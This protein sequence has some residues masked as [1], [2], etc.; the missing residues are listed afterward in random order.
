MRDLHEIEERLRQYAVLSAKDVTA[1]NATAQ[2]AAIAA[3]VASNRSVRFLVVLPDEKEAEELYEA[4]RAFTSTP[5]LLLPAWDVLPFE[6]SSLEPSIAA[7]RVESL[8]FLAGIDLP[9]FGIERPN[10]CIASARAVSRL[11]LSTELWHLLSKKISFAD[12]LPPHDLRKYLIESGYSHSAEVGLPGE[13]ASRGGILDFYSPG[14]LY[15]I[16]I[17]WDGDIIE[18]LR[19]F[20]PMTQRTID[21]VDSALILPPR[22]LHLPLEDDLRQE[23]IEQIEKELKPSLRLERFKDAIRSRNLIEG[24]ELFQTFFGGMTSA[25][26]LGKLN[27]ICVDKERIESRLEELFE[28]ASSESKES[29][30]GFKP[31]FLFSEALEADLQYD[32]MKTLPD[33]VLPQIE[34]EHLPASEVDARILRI[35]ISRLIDRDDEIII[36]TSFGSRVKELLSEEHIDKKNVNVIEGNLRSGARLPA[37]RIS[38]IGDEDI[39]GRIK[40]RIRKGISRRGR[41]DWRELNPGDYVVHVNH[42]VGIFRGIERIVSLGEERDVILIEYAEND[43]LYLPPHETGMLEKYSVLEGQTPRI[44]KLGAATWS[45]MRKRAERETAEIA[46]EL[47]DLYALRRATPGVI[48]PVSPSEESFEKTFGYDET[49][50]QMRAIEEVLGELSNKNCREPMDRLLCG[51][52]GY[53]KTEVA[54]R[55]TFRVV[56]NGKQVA[57]L[58]PTT[59]LALQH[60][61]TFKERLTPFGISVG[62]LS[63]FQSVHEIT[64]NLEKLGDGSLNVIIGTHKLFGQSVRFKDL[65]LVIVDEE[66]RFGVRHKE[67]L[68]ELRKRVDI[69]TLTATPIP[70]TLH[71]ALS[72]AKQL[73]MIETPPPGRAPIQTV[74]E[75]FNE[76]HVRRAIRRELDRG[77]QVFYVHNRIETIERVEQF[78]KR[79]FPKIPMAVAHGAMNERELSKVML[80]FISGKVSI[81]ISTSIIENG[82]DIPK[83]NTMIIDQAERFGLAQLYQLR[84]R[85]GRSNTKA[86]SYFFH[87]RDMTADARARLAAIAEYTELGS[88]YAIARRD[89]EIRG[90]GEILGVLQHGEMESV[91]YDMYCRLLRE[92]ISELKGEKSSSKKNKSVIELKVSAFIPFEWVGGEE[93]VAVVHREIANAESVAEV[94]DLRESLIDRF[95]GLPDPVENLL[96]IAE[97]RAYAT[98]DNVESIYENELDV[99][100]RWRKEPEGAERWLMSMKDSNRITYHSE[101]DILVIEGLPKT[102]KPKFNFLRRLVRR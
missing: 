55:A 43:R 14:N 90:A 25:F 30:L 75:P 17:A 101:G 40:R 98:L 56:R 76:E 47:L 73:S 92:A 18:S 46:R 53:G 1:T 9:K 45:R 54:L 52:V 31:E 68:K 80:D 96:R 6:P 72:G 21:T 19:L 60:S 70:R 95:G 99:R 13:F 102:S 35:D 39:F 50:D 93:V 62:T 57:V 28:E 59:V 26:K 44:D 34:T 33:G 2:S 12:E 69:L 24:M 67:K 22:E 88:G 48:Y 97:L 83:A 10:V 32:S 65:G 20:D 36:C 3:R 58:C 63:R 11:T 23:A 51:D 41:T 61:E 49:E 71:L 82:L 5:P 100:I 89:M 85:I 29:D 86:Y 87:S 27:I 4:L 66:Q 77:G 81:L 37:C 64:E 78:L 16:R 7:S 94:N 79:L 8:S 42:G 91:G 84:G 15:P 38:V 74:V